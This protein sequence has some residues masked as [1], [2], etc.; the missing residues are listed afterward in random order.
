[1]FFDDFKINETIAIEPVII[2]IDE[3]IAFAKRYD[4]IPLHTDEEYAKGTHF[5][6][7]IAPGVMSF[8][9]VWANYL[10]VD[11]AGEEL[12]AAKS[13]KIEWFKPVFAGD[14]LSAEVVVTSLTERNEKNGIVEITFYVKNQNGD[15]VLTDVTEMIVKKRREPMT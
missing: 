2:D 4:N 3:M 14:E 13:T 5:G 15:L 9:A 1:M 6:K 12:L 8:M 10:Q 7:L 11:L